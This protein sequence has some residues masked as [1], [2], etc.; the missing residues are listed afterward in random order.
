MMSRIHFKIIWS[1][2]AESRNTDR[3]GHE[4]TFFEAR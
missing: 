1:R 2:G 4:L 3:I